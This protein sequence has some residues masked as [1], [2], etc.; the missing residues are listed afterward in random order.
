M[1]GCTRT[2]ARTENRTLVLGLSI[3]CQMT[4][5]VFGKWQK[6]F[7]TKRFFLFYL[8]RT[9]VRLSSPPSLQS[10]QNISSPIFS[11]I[12]KPTKNR[13]SVRPFSTCP[14]WV[15]TER[16][17]ADFLAESSNQPKSN[18]SQIVWQFSPAAGIVRQFYIPHFSKQ[19]A[20]D[21]RQT[22]MRCA[23]LSSLRHR[24]EHFTMFNHLINSF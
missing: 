12:V 21:Q 24:T 13:T 9:C 3:Y 5:T 11:R 1:F 20:A 18:R 10:D 7:L 15:R 14:R 19:K 23:S 6:Q 2:V 4:K 16:M 17:F 8:I 22:V